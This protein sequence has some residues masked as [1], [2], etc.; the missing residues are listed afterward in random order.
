M[1]APNRR[2]ERRLDV[3]D[4]FRAAGFR[5]NSV[6]ELAFSEGS[7]KFLEGTGSMILD[8]MNRIAYCALSP[9]S[10]RD[11]LLGFCERLKWKAVAIR[12][13]QTIPHS[14]ERAEIYHTN[15]MFTLAESFAVVCLD[16]IDDKK[17][18]NDVVEVLISSGKEIIE[19]SEE[20]V[21]CFAGNMLQVCNESKERFL[22]MSKSA[23]DCLHDSQRDQIRKHCKIISVDISIIEKLGGGSAR[24]MLAEVFL[25]SI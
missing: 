5:V 25:P 13:L 4:R 12:A 22:V 18:R 15:V 14:G 20:Q 19:I 24:C 17:E 8:R 16:C 3:I 23:Y 1:C 6:I 10:D 7:S 9:R 11:L 2:L 21:A